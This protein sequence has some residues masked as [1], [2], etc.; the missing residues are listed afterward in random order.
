MPALVGFQLAVYDL[1]LFVAV[2]PYADVMIKCQP[3]ERNECKMPDKKNLKLAYAIAG[4]CIV[5]A[6]IAYAAASTGT[7]EE[8]VR[9]HFKATG[10]ENVLF[11]HMDHVDEFGYSCTAC[12]HEIAGEIEMMAESCGTCHESGVMR[13]PAFGEEEEGLFDHD[14]HSY[15]FGFSCTECHHEMDD[16]GMDPQRCSD[17]HEASGSGMSQLTMG[18]AAHQS[19]IDC[20]DAMGG[21]VEADCSSCHGPRGRTDAFHDQCMGCHEDEGKGPIEADCVGCHGF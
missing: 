3:L 6:V 9:A 7:P 19:C 11:G 10:Q 5:A 16:F 21:P 17:C 4:I 1:W 2:F 18:E 12:H 14:A 8:P 15:D 20:H 13:E